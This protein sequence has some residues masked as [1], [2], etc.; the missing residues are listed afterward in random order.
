MKVFFAEPLAPAAMM[1]G[2][3][4]QINCGFEA[5]SWRKNRAT[6]SISALSVPDAPEPIV[7]GG[8][9]QTPAKEIGL[10]EYSDPIGGRLYIRVLPGMPHV[11]SELG[12][13]RYEPKSHVLVREVS[14]VLR[15]CSRTFPMGNPDPAIGAKKNLFYLSR[16][17]LYQEDL[18]D[19]KKVPYKVTWDERN[20]TPDDLPVTAVRLK[21][22]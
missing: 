12:G 19:S 15:L 20:K 4:A 16:N 2:L 3:P 18:G 17:H 14:D 8:F 10:F 13:M 6:F 9:R 21:V 5:D 1:C 11:H 7:P 22:K